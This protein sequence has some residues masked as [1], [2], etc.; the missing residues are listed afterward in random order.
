[1]SLV[2]KEEMRNQQKDPKQNVL[3]IL[4]AEHSLDLQTRLPGTEVK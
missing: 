1:M 3:Q 4:S 2:D